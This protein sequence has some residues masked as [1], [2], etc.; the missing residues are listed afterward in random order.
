MLDHRIFSLLYDVQIF[1]LLLHD[2]DN[3]ISCHSII[4]IHEMHISSV[5]IQFPLTMIPLLDLLLNADLELRNCIYTVIY[6]TFM[7]HCQNGHSKVFINAE[8]EF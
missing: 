5:S 7:V 8:S 6:Q 2:Y 1:L 4:I 3:A